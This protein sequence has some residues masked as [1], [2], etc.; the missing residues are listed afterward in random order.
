MRRKVLTRRVLKNTFMT[1]TNCVR[2]LKWDRLFCRDRPNAPPEGHRPKQSQIK[3]WTVGCARE[4]LAILWCSQF[5]HHLIKQV[6]CRNSRA[7]RLLISSMGQETIAARSAKR[8][9][10]K[11]IRLSAT[12]A[13]AGAFRAVAP[14]EALS[15]QAPTRMHDEPHGANPGQAS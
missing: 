11:R 8:T 10:A 12:P 6:M 14:W 7:V 15:S 9:D 13:E 5:A 1:T 4:D 3:G 2:D